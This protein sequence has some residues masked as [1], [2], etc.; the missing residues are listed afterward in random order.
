MHVSKNV[1]E[2]LVYM[3]NGMDT[4]KVRREEEKR[5]RF[6]ETWVETSGE[7][8]PLPDAP[9]HLKVN[10][11]LLADKRLMSIKVP[12]GTD[13]KCQKL[14]DKSIS[15]HMK[16]VHW[17]HILVSGIL[18]YC[19][20]GVLGDEQRYKLCDIISALTSETVDAKILSTELYC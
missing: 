2:H 18:K 10:E 16:S 8:R 6:Q 11:V 15:I 5:G 17:R 20:R 9:F 4:V 19:I 3:L 13:W 1:G 14:F 12:H 7:K